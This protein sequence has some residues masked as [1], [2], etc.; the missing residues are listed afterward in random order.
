MT[1][2]RDEPAP[3]EETGVGWPGAPSPARKPATPPAKPSVPSPPP[4]PAPRRSFEATLP[5]VRP[6]TVTAAAVI[7][8]VRSGFGLLA[9]CALS[10]LAGNADLGPNQ[11]NLLLLLSVILVVS[12]VLNILFGYFV[13]QGRQ[14]ARVAA[15]VFSAVDIVLQA[16]GLFG[17]TQEGSTMAGSC[18]GLVLSVIIIGLLSGSSASEYFRATRAWR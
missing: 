9:C 11:S 16:V 10:L 2:P 17:G 3:I 8:F 18:I 14:W 1:T 12:G 4:R 7:M 5:P 6:G 13:L 15:I